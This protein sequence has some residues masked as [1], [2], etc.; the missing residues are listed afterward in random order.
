M[1]VLALLGHAQTTRQNRNQAAVL[2][3]VLAVGCRI[4][5]IVSTNAAAVRTR[6]SP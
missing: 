4:C 3:F 2:A 1:L 6:R 5:G